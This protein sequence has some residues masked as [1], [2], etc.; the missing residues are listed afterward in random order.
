MEGN[1]TNAPRWLSE[2]G[3]LQVGRIPSTGRLFY[4]PHP[5]CPG[6]LEEAEV[7]EVSGK[8]SIY[9]YSRVEFGPGSP[10]VLALVTLAEGPTM[11]T[12]IVDADPHG[13]TVGMDVELR[14][15]TDP[16]GMTRPDF[17]PA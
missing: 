3:K 11:M 12:N 6:T 4:P 16:S 2:A 15:T 5:I 1:S 8:G 17:A 13:L 7:V 10:Y 14:V 9:S